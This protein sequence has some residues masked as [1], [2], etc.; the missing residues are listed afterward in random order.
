MKNSE[1]FQRAKSLM[2]GGVSSPVRAFKAVGG[3]PILVARAQGSRLWDVEGK[4]YIDFLMSWGPLILGHAHPA[5]VNAV[6]EQAQKGLSYGLT[7]IH[8]ITLAELVVS[9]MP[10]VEMVRFVSSGTEATMSAIRLA[11]GYTGRRYVVKFDGCYHGHGD[12]LLVSAGSGVAT[13]G[14]PG[15]PGVPEEVARLT[16]VVPYND[17]EAL[18]EVFRRYGEEIACVI[19]EPVAGNM[20]VVL[21]KEGFLEAIR[22]IT[23]S[24]GALVICDEVITNFRLSKGGAQELFDIDPDITCMGKIIGGGM[25]L[26]AYG[27]RREVMEKVAPEGPVY[28]AGTLSGNPLSMVAGI[29]TLRELFRLNPYEELE[30]LTKKL[31][32]GIGEVLSRKGIAHRIN[33]IASMFTIFFTEKEVYDYQTAKS[34]DRE[35]FGRFFRLLLKEGVLIPP[36]QFEAWF[37]STAHTEEDIDLALERI[38]RAVASL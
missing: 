7:N 8:E 38:E 13:L 3:E 10:S 27:G 4:E 15:T 21:P 35:L 31:T 9:A 6:S 24:Y 25:P 28:Q 26:G 37:L 5:V 19:V 2:P 33:Q 29:A 23:R 12:A 18:K 34:S 20:G 1:L 17:V 14:I 16:L 22:D 32:S 36:A 11:R 30:R